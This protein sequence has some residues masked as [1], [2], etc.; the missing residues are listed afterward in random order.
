MTIKKYINLKASVLSA[1]LVLAVILSGIP[2]THAN[3]LNSNETTIT[4]YHTN[5]MH[6]KVNSIY[7]SGELKQIGL[8][9]IKNIKDST[10]NSILVDAGD[11]TQGSPLGKFSKG[12]DIIKLMNKT[13]YDVM[14]IGNHEFDYGKDAVMDI[15][16]NADFPILSANTLYN[17]NDFLASIN[18]YNG[19]NFIKEINGKKIGFFG[20]TTSETTK[21][22]IP[23][24]LEGITFEDEIETSKKQVKA[25]K[26]QG[27]DVTIGIAHV[28]IESSS[29][30]KSYDIAKAVDGLDIII[31]G[32]SHTKKTETVF[33]TL[34][35]Q[36]GT[37]SST[38]GKINI[39]FNGNDFK[40]DAGLLT[41][42]EVQ[43]NYTPDQNV[44]NYYNELYSK[45]APTLEKVIG[46][47]DSTLFG[48]NYNSKNISRIVEANLGDLIGDAM[49]YESK[50]LL[51]DSEY[52]NL[53]IVALENGGSVRS[54]IDKGF[55]T[56]EDVLEVLPLDNKLTLQVITP[57]I[58][59]QTMERGVC[60]IKPPAAKG[61]SPDGFFGGFPQ[62]AGMK[63]EFDITQ[64]A[65]DTNTPGDY[66]GQR[67]T[68][69]TLIDQ[70]GNNN[71]VLDRS[72]DQTKLIFACN[73][74]TVT[75][76]PMVNEVEILT[77]GDY[78][79]NTL[80]NYINKL[81]FDSGEPIHNYETKG[82]DIL[83]NQNEYAENFDSKIQIFSNS[84]LL[85][86]EEVKIIIDNDKEM[87]MTTDENGYVYINSLNYSGHTIKVFYNNNYSDAYID[88][89]AGLKDAFI[90]IDD[91]SDRDIKCVINLIDQIPD[92]VTAENAKLL[93]FARTSYNMLN[94]DNQA[95]V[96]NYNKLIKAENDLN[97]L[98]NHKQNFI[99]IIFDNPVASAIIISIT[100]LLILAFT[101]IIIK[102]KKSKID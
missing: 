19:C 81:T 62:I 59:Y 6:G 43:K 95:K 77:K 69:I 15:A 25:L 82:R 1:I 35:Q 88:P 29:K 99:S 31:D 98:Y 56:M 67:V 73:D 86:S 63:I 52:K 39:T 7:S 33:G 17:G 23:K 61:E 27:A 10:A 37:E 47:T 26:E 55:I 102:K 57:K 80:A 14:T 20:I 34:I 4:I 9:Y 76:Y 65:Y 46:A 13:S 72:D 58:L 45:I 30:I 24:N 12:I 96:T 21:T 91:A 53:P 64:E 75:E 32:H 42:N 5:D 68:K 22:T 97:N 100:V 44:T 70:E 101:A 41:A 8:D 79:S 16:K 40:I 11:A 48:G 84:N 51:K 50:N 2:L 78:L 89:R 36:T 90:F 83:L 49:I 94:N 71:I 66:K 93:K 38:L 18:G 74:Y 3:N 54:R 85:K 87:I 28:G 60:K 92:N